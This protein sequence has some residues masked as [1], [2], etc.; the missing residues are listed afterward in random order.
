MAKKERVQEMFNGI[1]PKYDL[2]NHLLSMGIDKRWRKKAMKVV[3]AGC[4]D[5][6]LDVACG[7]GD[8]SMEALKHG[9]KKVIGADISENMLTVAREKAKERKLT[10]QLDFRYGDSENLEFPDNTFDAV[11]V[12]FGV[13]NFEHLEKGLT[14]MYR[15]LKPG[16]KVVILEFSTPERFPMKQL[17]RFYFKRVLPWIGGIVSGNRKAYEYLPTSVFAFPQGEAFLKIM[18]SCGYRQVT[19]CRLT[20]GIASLYVGEK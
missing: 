11:T 3:G 10:E 9:V 2:L 6:V 1:A 19:Q 13:R 17:Y 8:F 12:A 7:T 4:K 18:R 5:I 15:V 16:G 20:F 14:E